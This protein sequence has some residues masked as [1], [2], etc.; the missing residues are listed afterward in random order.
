MLAELTAAAGFPP[1]VVNVIA[2][3]NDTGQAIVEHPDVRL[4]SLTGSTAAGK[5]VMAAAAPS[6]KRVHFELGG[7]APFLVFDD[8]D[9][10]LVAEKA[11]FAASLNTGQDCTAA[12]RIYVTPGKQKAVT[13]AVV[14]AM[15]AV[16]LG[17]PFDDSVKMGPLISKIQKDRVE[18]FVE[19]A[20]AQKAAVLTGGAAPDHWSERG[21]YYAPTVITNVA[22]DSEIIQA[23]VFGPV[24]TVSAIKDDAEAVRLANDV[25]YGLAASVWTRDIGRAMRL[26]KDLE[27]GAVWIND[28]MP[29]TSE[30]PHGGFK[31]SGFGKDLSHESVKNYKVTKHVMVTHA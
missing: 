11:A 25:P 10:G 29:L 19:R 23:E 13:E 8:A 22:Q 3:G 21:Y 18:G 12:T 17:D 31:Q 20:R 27:F 16:K 4:I 6:L 5:K 30:T 9:P 15:R 2:G 26:S 7:K 1:G 28:H 14:E 24:I